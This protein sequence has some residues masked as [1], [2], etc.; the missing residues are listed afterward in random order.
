MGC[1]D[2]SRLEFLPVIMG[3]EHFKPYIDGLRVFLDTDPSVNHT[4]V[5]TT[6]VAV[7]HQLD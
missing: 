2:A 3:L 6:I 5:L 1:Y 7:Y 4:R